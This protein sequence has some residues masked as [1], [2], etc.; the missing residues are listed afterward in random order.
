MEKKKSKGL[1]KVLFTPKS[2][3]GCCNVQFEEIAEEKDLTDKE[4]K[5]SEN[6]ENSRS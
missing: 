4:T 1:I 5:N 6:K 3:T 2:N